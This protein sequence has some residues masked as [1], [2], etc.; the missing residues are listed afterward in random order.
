MSVELISKPF[1]EWH[2]N[3]L[4]KSYILY[5]K[6]F[7]IIYWFFRWWLGNECWNRSTGG[8]FLFFSPCKFQ[9]VLQWFI[10]LACRARPLCAM[11]INGHLKLEPL[12][13]QVYGLDVPESV[14]IS[15]PPPPVSTTTHIT[16][17]VL[18]LGQKIW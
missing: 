17:W 4:D 3:Q 11:V 13:G 9:A 12:I 16:Q 1:R 15:S 14:C 18:I 5:C 6:V 8:E 7:R 10:F 2:I